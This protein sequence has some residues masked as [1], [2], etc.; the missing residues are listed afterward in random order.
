[1]VQ[2]L[3]R[4]WSNAWIGIQ[5]AHTKIILHC[6]WFLYSS[7]VSSLCL[8]MTSK[9]P[10]LSQ[11][12]RVVL[13]S[14][15]HTLTNEYIIRKHQ[16]HMTLFQYANMFSAKRTYHGCTSSLNKPTLYRSGEQTAVQLLWNLVVCV[17]NSQSPSLFQSH[18]DKRE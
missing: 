9:Y 15:L 8:L 5:L 2:I 14:C 17:H 16:Q 6:A 3:P 7:P 18:K 12:E 11:Y 4:L 13:N 1:M 10:S